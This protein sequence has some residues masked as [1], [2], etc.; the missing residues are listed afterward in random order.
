MQQTMLTGSPTSRSDGTT[1]VAHPELASWTWDV[2]RDLATWSKTLFDIFGLPHSEKTPSLLEHEQIYTPGSFK[3]IQSAVSR[4][5]ETGQPYS[6][7][8][9]GIHS[10]GRTIHL[11]AFGE[12]ERDQSGRVAKIFGQ[13][14]DVSSQ[15]TARRELDYKNQ[16]IRSAFG[17][18]SIGMALLSLDGEWLEV[19]PAIV[20][21]F[22]YPLEELKQRTVFQMTHPE[23][24]EKCLSL[25]DRLVCGDYESYTLNKRYFHKSGA[26]VWTHL[27][28][29]LAKDE[30]QKPL[31]LICHMKDLTKSVQAEAA[32]QENERLLEETSEVAKV[33]GWH[34]D[35]PTRTLK[36]TAQTRRIH[37][38]GDDFVPT[39]ES[40]LNFYPEESRKKIDQGIAAAIANGTKRWEL[41]V[42]IITALGHEIWVNAIGHAGL[43]DG[44]VVTLHGTIQDI[45]SSVQAESQVKQEHQKLTQLL[46][47][48]SRVSIIQTDPRGIITI[49]NEGAKNLLGYA[50][51]EILNKTT[52]TLIHL[53]SEIAQRGRELS[54]QLGCT[55][56]GFEV[57][58]AIPR[59][60]GSETREWTYLRKDG[61][62]F[63]VS[64]VVTCI[65]DQSGELTGY[66]GIATDL[67][68]I[69]QAEAESRYQQ[70]LIRQLVDTVPDRV[71]FK[72]L[73]SRMIMANKLILDENDLK[74]NS[75]LKGVTDHDF[76]RPGW[77]N[78]TA[79]MRRSSC[80][81]E[82][83]SWK[84]KKNR[85]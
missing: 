84:S 49:F 37:E 81:R 33:G 34:L 82:N 24:L 53:E 25:L 48:A 21:M 79:K 76:S 68:E 41:K 51:E 54:A 2:E 62:E 47:A 20:A 45:T 35:L 57:F 56:E 71:Y 32:L 31:H 29:S 15:E 6:L 5:L 9:E 58:T 43:K 65:R 61:T 30:N 12:A 11:R 74:D 23:D 63:P 75:E 16:L 28:A 60:S 4:C 10:T 13:V 14:I 83:R 80:K 44:R 52:P 1:F 3:K 55:V 18:A 42:P 59:L 46:N 36:W 19:N 26:I 67:T 22:G 77:R 50:R 70:T 38:V 64:L 27:T 66:L 17:N 72:D 8:L 40:A 39:L 78:N 7:D 73:D 69:R 85:F